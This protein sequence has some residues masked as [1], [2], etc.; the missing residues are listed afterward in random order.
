MMTKLLKIFILLFLLFSCSDRNP[1]NPFDPNSD[2]QTTP[3]QGEL[4]I[5]QL[6]DSQVTL[7]WQLNSSIKGN[8]IIK[9]KINLDNDYVILDSVDIN[10]SFYNDTALLTTN[11]YYYQLI[12]ANGVV[13]TEPLSNSINPAFAEITD[14]NIQQENIITAKL[15]WQHDCDYEE[16]YIIERRETTSRKNNFYNSKKYPYTKIKSAINEKNSTKDINAKIDTDPRDFIQI[17]NLPANSIE[18]IDEDV[19]PNILYEYKIHSYT[20][21]NTSDESIIIYDNAIP[22]PVD[23]TY[24]KLSISSIK[25]TWQDSCNGENGFKIDKKV[26]AND[27]QIEYDILNEDT[28]EWIDE[29]AEINENLQYRIYAFSGE[30][31]STSIETGIIDNTFPAPS[32]LSYEQLTIMSIKLMWTD[33]SIGEEGF[34]IDKKVGTNDWQLEYS[35]VEENIEDWT[36]ENAEINEDIQYRIHAYN[37]FNQS[38]TIVFELIDNTLPAPS[39]LTFDQLNINSIELNW[40]DNSIGENGFKIDKKVGLNAWQIEYAL[41]GENVNTWTDSNAEINENI[42]YR[43][44]AFYENYSSDSVETGIIDNEIPI[45]QELSYTIDYQSPTIVD[46]HLDWT[47]TMNGIEG[48]KVKKNGIL[49]AEIIPDGITEWVDF[50]VNV[51]SSN[52]YQVLAFYQNYNSAYSNEV[53]FEIFADMIFVQGGTFDMGDHYNEG[54]F[55]ELP[56]HE[57]LLDD[58]FIRQIEVTH[59]EFIEFLNDY[60]IDSNGYYNGTEIINMNENECAIAHNGT[61]FFFSGS[62]YATSNECPVFYVTWHGA[63]LYCNWKSVL[64]NLQECYNLADWNCD[65]SANGYRLPTEAEWEYAARGG[66]DWIDDFRYSGCHDELEL[67][68]YAWYIANSNTQ[69]HPVETK[70]SNQLDIHDMSGNVMEWCN[71]WY[72]SYSS[73][74]F[75]NPTGPENGTS[76]VLRGGMANASAFALRVSWR[77]FNVSN[78]SSY[79]MGFRFIKSIENN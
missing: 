67:P 66:E 27:W 78:S 11:T 31:Q 64:N 44:L 8:Y 50:G 41:I 54:N 38:S 15:T 55:D 75:V 17:A 79:H 25:L 43:V 40:D 70:L 19:I 10:S 62:S 21:L 18:F 1:Q 74:Y 59:F 28:E 24:E 49:L 76:R 61:S 35:V 47:Y 32:N 71:D 56:I 69:T 72:S 45:P 33:N 51:Q 73:G 13:Q 48:F 63:A 16:G 42:Q 29:N 60:G 23:L 68:D 20:S 39:N 12:G 77:S 3:M 9:R 52:S 7:G 37:G 6:T 53:I 58:Y 2:Y 26:G 34:K 57:V 14:F 5:Y 30:N 46:I 36:D 65:F 22:S 4:H